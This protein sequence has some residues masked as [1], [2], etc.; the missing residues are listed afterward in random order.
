ME[1]TFK[2]KTNGFA[3]ATFKD[4]AKTFET[5]MKQLEHARGISGVQLAYV[6][7]KNLIPLDE[8]DNPPT[9]YL[10]LDA[11]VIACAQIL[12]EHVAFPGQSAKAIALLEENRP[13]CDTFCINIVTVWNI[14]F[15]MF[16]QTPAWLH[17]A[18]TRKEK[19]G[20]KLYHLLFAHY[21]GSDHMNHLANK[22]EARLAS[23][24]YRGEQKNWDWSHYIDAH[25]EQ[26]TI[27]KNLMEHGYSGL[28]ECSKLPAASIATRKYCNF[29]GR[30]AVSKKPATPHKLQKWDRTASPPHDGFWP[31]L[32]Q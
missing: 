1:L 29:F 6:P 3:Q 31:F 9:N 7:R 24:T 8:D 19:N 14:L 17:A 30:H 11:K 5:V 32:G 21:L 25:I 18:L 22:M 4:L 28:D 13:F 23:L 12:E 26:H 10:S 2:N 16:G 27:T 15:E 20:R